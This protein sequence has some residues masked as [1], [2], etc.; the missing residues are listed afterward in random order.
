MFWYWLENCSSLFDLNL[1]T[2]FT[3]ICRYCQIGGCQSQNIW[4]GRRVPGKTILEWQASA[5]PKQRVSEK[6]HRVMLM[7]ERSST[8]WCFWCVFP[9]FGVGDSLFNSW[10]TA[11][12]ERERIQNKRLFV[13]GPVS[14]RLCVV[15]ECLELCA[16]VSF[17][18]R[19]HSCFFYGPSSQF[20]RINY[21]K[22]TF[23]TEC[24]DLYSGWHSTDDHWFRNVL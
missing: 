7:P 1:E 15:P 24:V 12:N 20:V 5:W 18:Y 10:S 16:C 8:H 6:S 23:L 13:S 11:C 2:N 21:D 4:N 17:A 9:C 14:E 3:D 22:Y 19:L